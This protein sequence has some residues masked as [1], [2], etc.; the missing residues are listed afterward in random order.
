MR[1]ELGLLLLRHSQYDIHQALRYESSE[2][3]SIRTACRDLLL[4]HVDDRTVQ[5]LLLLPAPTDSVLHLWASP[6][7]R[8]RPESVT[9]S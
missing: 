3:C 4:H 9:S 1:H 5:A 8:Q 7:L 2:A 6:N